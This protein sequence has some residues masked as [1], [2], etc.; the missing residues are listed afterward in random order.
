[1]C[2][3]LACQ[4]LNPIITRPA[5]TKV[6]TAFL[7]SSS[8]SNF[9][10]CILVSFPFFSS[11]FADSTF[12]LTVDTGSLFEK[13][14]LQ[15]S[16]AFLVFALITSSS[17]AIFTGVS[18]R[19]AFFLHFLPPFCVFLGCALGNGLISSGENDSGVVITTDYFRYSDSGV[20][21][22]KA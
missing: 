10:A 12:E 15:S 13:T 3:V 20:V 1:M 21:I 19:I 9:S 6:F 18:V 8:S 4:P 7:N 16:V 2:P 17:N 14:F 22:I 5:V 11:F